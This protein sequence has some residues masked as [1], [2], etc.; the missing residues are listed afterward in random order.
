N[1]YTVRGDEGGTWTYFTR[2]DIMN[3]S[4]PGDTI[5]RYLEANME[6]PNSGGRM[7]CAYELFGKDDRQRTQYIYLWAA[8]MEYCVKDGALML[9]ASVSLP[10]VLSAEGTPRGLMIKSHRKPVDGESY[11][12]SIRKMFPVKYHEAI[13]SGGQEY[14]R[15]AKGLQ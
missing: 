6:S 4:A 12:A 2:I 9:G 15:R 3:Q 5:Q 11:G 13:F 10:V 8:C 7:F 1:G 14:N